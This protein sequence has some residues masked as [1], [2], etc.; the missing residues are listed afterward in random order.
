VT[1]AFDDGD[2][3]DAL[4]ELHEHLAAYVAAQE[5]LQPLRDRPQPEPPWPDP[6]NVM[7]DFLIRR[8]M[9]LAEAEGPEAAVVWV[10]VHAWREAALDERARIIRTLQD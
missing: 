5:G 3:S 1:D 8:G 10:A 2:D 4:G 6:A 7:L 9:E